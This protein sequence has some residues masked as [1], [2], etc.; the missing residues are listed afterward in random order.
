M[1]QAVI[2]IPETRH[3][4]CVPAGRIP[5]ERQVRYPPWPAASPP[6]ASGRGFK[7]LGRIGL[8]AAK[9][10]CGFIKQIAQTHE[11]FGLGCRETPGCFETGESSFGIIDGIG[12]RFFGK[13]DLFLKYFKIGIMH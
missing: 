11:S 2:F 13:L 6:Q 7:P 1:R 12:Q 8:I 10:P 3:V 9:Y 5:P 4:R